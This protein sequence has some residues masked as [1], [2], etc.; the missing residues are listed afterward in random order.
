M[1]K[2]FKGIRVHHKNSNLEIFGAV[3][4]V[5]QNKETGQLHIVDYKSTA[6]KGDPSIDEGG[7]GEAY[8]KTNGNLS[9]A[10]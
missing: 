1:E 10:F 8:K 4:D 7:F 3:D 9:V 2:Q 6:K 5:W